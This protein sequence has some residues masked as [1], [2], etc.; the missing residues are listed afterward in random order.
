MK[1]L[2][3]TGNLTEETRTGYTVMSVL[4]AFLFLACVVAYVVGNGSV[5]PLALKLLM[6]SAA[7]IELGMSICCLCE[8]IM[9]R[10]G[11]V[12]YLSVAGDTEPEEF[13][14]NAKLVGRLKCGDLY[15]RVSQD[16]DES[17]GSWL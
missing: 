2:S 7:T 15:V 13:P 10:G 5:M 4:S 3:I 11:F 6:L 12:F 1:G 14:D 8:V 17:D 9:L 16:T